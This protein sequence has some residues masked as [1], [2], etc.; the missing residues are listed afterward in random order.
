MVCTLRPDGIREIEQHLYVP[1]G[2][3]FR[4][5][6][7]EGEANGGQG[8]APDANSYISAGIGFC[9]MTQF[10]RY[11]K[12][13]KTDL[14]KYSIIQDTHF[15]LGGATGQTGKAGTTDPVETHVF[16][17]SGNDDEVAQDTLFMSEQTCFLHALCRTDLK[18][19]VRLVTPSSNANQN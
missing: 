9:F 7:E 17:H 18:P 19:K 1:R 6:S 16:L 11:A 5:L 8:R 2:T 12:I 3:I 4:F 14:Q 13:M 10:G 15:S